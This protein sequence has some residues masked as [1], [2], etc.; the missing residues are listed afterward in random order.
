MPTFRY[1]AVD[2][3]GRVNTGTLQAYDAREVQQLLSQRGLR[4]QHIVRVPDTSSASSTKA[5][6][7]T[8]DW[9]VSTLPPTVMTRLLTQ[10]YALVKAGFPLSEAFRQVSG[11]V[12]H[13][14]LASAC[15][16]IAQ[17]ATQGVP[18][19]QAMSEYPRLFPAFVIGNIRAGELGGYLPDALER[20]VKYYER[21]RSYR[22]WSAPAQGCFWMTLLLL[23]IVTSFGV[24]LVNSIK[25][26]TGS[27]SQSEALAL[28]VQG[29]WQ[30]FL[31]VGLPIGGVLMGLWGLWVW[32]KRVAPVR[33]R[34]QLM[35]PIVW[36]FADWVR[37]QSLQIFLFHL[38]R[39]ANVGLPPATVWETASRTVPNF[40]IACALASIHLDSG[41]RAEHLDSALARSGMFPPEEVAMVATGVQSG[42]V[43]EMLQ[44]LAT[45]YQQRSQEASRRV[46]TGLIRLALLITIVGTGVALILFAWGWYGNIGKAIDEWFGTP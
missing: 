30:A 25:Q 13:R 17:K 41:E 8:P 20:L 3:H 34:L 2:S 39:L 29:W 32:A 38:A 44:R 21:W 45:Y 16:E 31:K 12:R 42:Q 46:P 7:Q 9:E 6:V 5:P 27:E 15:V 43:V 18:V 24:G 19:S 33:A 35:T 28:I 1:Q 10:V 22:L 36:G 40:A 23:P 26:F 14:K 37:A 11:R 4:V